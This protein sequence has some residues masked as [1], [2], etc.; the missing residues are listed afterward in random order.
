M[1][2]LVEELTSVTELAR[3]AEN[4]RGMRS[5]DALVR[6]RRARPSVMGTNSAVVAVLL[7]NA[8]SVAA[9]TMITTSSRSVSSPVKRRM[10]RHHRVAAEPGERLFGR[11]QAGEDEG[12]QDAYSDHVG[13]QSLQR[14]EHHRDGDDKQEQRDLWGH[15]AVGASP[16]PTSMRCHISAGSQPPSPIW[17][18]VFCIILGII[19]AII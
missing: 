12:Q 11:Q 8:L 6:V 3:M 5:F 15:Q 4:A 19:C 7:M 14:E 10:V 1:T 18:I 2:M 9:A 16:K 17:A 13:R